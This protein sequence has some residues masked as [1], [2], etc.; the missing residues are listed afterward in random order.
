MGRGREMMSCAHRATCQTTGDATL[1][2]VLGALLVDLMLL[3]SWNYGIRVR[4][5]DVRR[6]RRGFQR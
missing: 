1:D 5:A 3:F 6:I 2:N 4:R